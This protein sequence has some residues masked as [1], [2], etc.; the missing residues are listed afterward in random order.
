MA[1]GPMLAI[2]GCSKKDK[3]P[4]EKVEKSVEGSEQEQVEDFEF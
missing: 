1:I 3:K 4:A 2:A